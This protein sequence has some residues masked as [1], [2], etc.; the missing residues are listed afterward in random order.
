RWSNS[1]AYIEHNRTD[2]QLWLTLY[3]GSTQFTTIYVINIETGNQ[4]SIYNFAFAHTCYK[5]VNNEMLIGGS[6]GHLYR[7]YNDNSRYL[8]NAVSYSTDTR[9]RG[10]MTN[11]SLPFNRKHN[12][13][14]YIQ[15]YG[16][17]GLTCTVNIYT[18][19]DFDTPVYTKSITLA[20]GNPLI[21]EDGQDVI[22]YT[23]SSIIGLTVL[24]E[25]DIQ[26]DKK[27]N[28]TSLMFELT[29]IG[30]SLGAE[31]YGIDFSGAITGGG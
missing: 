10:A 30:G 4:L 11:W 6:D 24:A 20:G 16:A 3:N 27:F 22:I 2:N 28:Y 12:K 14:I 21:F 15:L 26:I 19:D 18:D 1:N 23:M 5:F 29:N 9:I 31:F 17:S 7:L 13:K 8:D 25:R